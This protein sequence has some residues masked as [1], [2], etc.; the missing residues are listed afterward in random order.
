MAG[1]KNTVNPLDWKAPI[2]NKDGTPT[3]EFQR[4]WQQQAATNGQIPALSTAAEVSAILDIIGETPGAMLYRATTGEWILLA[5][6]TDGYILKYDATDTKPEWVAFPS[7]SSLLDTLGSTEGDIITRGAGGWEVLSPPGT[8]GWVL[9]WNAATS[10]PIWKVGGAAAANPTATAS[11]TAVNGVATTLMRSDAAPAVQKGSATQ[12]GIFKVDGTTVT[13]VGGVLSSSGGGAGPGT[14][15]TIVQSAV[16]TAASGS[17]TLG[18][19]PTNGNLLVA[20][21]FNPSTGSP[22]TGWTSQAANTSGTDFAF[23]ATKVAGAGESA[24][25]SP[26]SGSPSSAG[27]VIWEIH[28]QNATAPIVLSSVPGPVTATA[29]NSGILPSLTNCLN[30]AA[31]CISGS[32]GTITSIVNMTQDQLANTGTRRIV[33]A[34]STAST[35]IAILVMNISASLQSKMGCIQVTS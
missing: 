12:F 8:D 4:K 13:A 17:V 1:I 16:S 2:V 32:S 26:I 3:Q 23:I 30:L 31:G 18:A 19:A 7:I 20:I 11:D 15:P 14:P 21:C 24:T 9:T 33:G 10:L 34:H 6:G 25:Q 27:I 22:G 29:N 5:P 35:A 28:G